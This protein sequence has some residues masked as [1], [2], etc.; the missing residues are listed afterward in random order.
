[1][2]TLIQDVL[3]ALHG[4]PFVVRFLTLIAAIP[5]A[6]YTYDWAKKERL[7]PGYPLIALDGKTPEDSWINFPKE[8]LVKGANLY[9]DSPFQV[10]SNSGPKLII[11]QKYADEVRT[12]QNLNFQKS[13]LADFPWKLPGFKAFAMQEQDA[14]VLPTVVRTKLTS[15]LASLV[16]STKDEIL[17]VTSR[18]YGQTEGKEEWHTITVQAD[19][20]YLI[21]R[22]TLRMMLGEKL[23]CND[24]LVKIHI[25]HANHIFGAGNEVRAFP[26][27]VWPIVHWFL[28]GCQALRQN[29]KRGCDIMQE[30]VARREEEARKMMAAGKKVAKHNDSVGWHVEVTKGRDYDVNTAQLA[31][32]MAALH[33][34]G[35]VS[36]TVM[37]SSLARMVF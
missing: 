23:S 21:A 18:L 5:L 37:L 9:P 28:P 14:T 32:S 20:Q 17:K 31:L 16:E 15:T 13:F 30:E 27:V 12:S 35:T 34:T 1:M 11:P 26:T 3:S 7:F 6:L 29:L 36:T 22:T 33:N 10:V 24:E 8:T 25:S 4:V 19:M 2:A